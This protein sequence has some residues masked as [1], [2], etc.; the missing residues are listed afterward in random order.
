MPGMRRRE[1][2][3]LLG[4]AAAAWPLAA[5][6]QQA[7]MPVIGFLTPITRRVRGPSAR[8]SQGPGGS[9]LCRRENVAIEY[10]WAEDQ[11]DRLPALAA[12]LVG[13]Q[14][15]VIAA[16]DVPLRLAAKAATTTI[17]I[18]FTVGDDP[19][20][21]GLV[22]SLARPGGN[23]TGINY[24]YRRS[25]AKRLEL[26]RELVPGAARYCR[27]RQSGGWTDYR[28]GAAR[29]GTGGSRD[30][31]A[32]PWPPRLVQV[33]LAISAA[34]AG[35]D[36]SRERGAGVR[37]A[38]AAAGLTL[39]DDAVRYGPIALESGAA[40]MHELLDARVRP[41]A[42]IATNDVFAVGAMLAC[43][44]AGVR[45]P[46]RRLDHRRRQHRPRRNAD[47]RAH[48]HP[49]AD[50]RDR[51]RR[52]IGSF[53]HVSKVEPAELQQLLPFELVKRGSTGPPP[54]SARAAPVN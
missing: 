17:P 46:R 51:P 43:R 26:L 36:R 29:R 45:D 23:L 49:H 1:F 42:V 19:V 25:R 28:G 9:R 48:E 24:F 12:D 30:E 8:F 38:L 4:G 7:A 31:A 5:R 40:A 15:A 16:V 44:E 27:T 6:A 52:R 2:I 39:A 10:R 34:T 18:V 54:G 3:T 14:V 37:A 35:N 20:R 50:R 11:P 22:A 32:T 53:S 13:R 21:L 33:G 41:T 47:A